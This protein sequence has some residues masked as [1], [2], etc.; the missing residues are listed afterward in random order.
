MPS[1][2]QLAYWHRPKSSEWKQKVSASLRQSPKARAYWDRIK[3][4]EHYSQDW[5]AKHLHGL[6]HSPAP[7]TAR[8]K[9]R[10][11][12]FGMS[13][14]QLMALHEGQH[15]HCA[16]CPEPWTVVDHDHATGTVR[17]LLC[18]KCNSAL[19]FLKDS[20]VLAHKAAFYLA[21]RCQIAEVS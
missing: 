6:H 13:V 19:G 12:R 9:R 16:I 3:G 14:E 8:F 1:E 15:G 7:G 5:R 2:R 21:E 10:A 18:R 17:G 4:S 20:P 11:S